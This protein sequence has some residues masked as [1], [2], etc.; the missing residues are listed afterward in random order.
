[1]GEDAVRESGAIIFGDDGKPPTADQTKYLGDFSGGW[2]P[3]ASS[4]AA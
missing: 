2:K 4:H 3:P 1:M